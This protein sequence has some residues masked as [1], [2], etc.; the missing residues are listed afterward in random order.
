VKTE[1][2]GAHFKAEAKPAGA[3]ALVANTKRFRV[4]S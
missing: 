3:A 2:D 1:P 4:T